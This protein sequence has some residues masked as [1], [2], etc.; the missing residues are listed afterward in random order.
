MDVNYILIVY[1]IERYIQSF[2]DSFTPKAIIL[3]FVTLITFFLN[4]TIAAKY[5]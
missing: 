5:K 3:E 2:N 4:K 1:L